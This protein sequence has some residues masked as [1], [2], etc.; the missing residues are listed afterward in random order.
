M[1]E[2]EM[3]PIQADEMRNK[4][5]TWWIGRKV[6]VRYRGQEL[7]A[8]VLHYFE[9]EDETLLVDCAGVSQSFNMQVPREPIKITFKDVIGV[10]MSENQVEV[11]NRA[12]TEKAKAI[13]REC[14]DA[15][16]IDLRQ[17]I[18]EEL[19]MLGKS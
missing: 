10:E 17:F 16:L 2:D 5:A 18:T 11:V 4:G 3:K 12:R 13:L 7:H 15:E 14:T 9:I 6:K 1:P 8:R 19:I